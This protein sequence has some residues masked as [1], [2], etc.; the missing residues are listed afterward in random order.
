MICQRLNFGIKK[1][2]VL[3]QVFNNRNKI[4]ALEYGETQGIWEITI[5][6]K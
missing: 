6:T 1:Y 4:Y 5:P 2:G 3:L